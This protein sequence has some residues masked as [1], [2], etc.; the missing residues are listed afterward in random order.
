MTGI[1][2]NT[3]LRQTAKLSPAQIQVIRMLEIPAVELRQRVEEEIQ[4]NPLLEEVPEYERKDQET[5][6][7]RD[8]YEDDYLYED[9]LSDSP[10]KGDELDDYDSF[11]DPDE[12]YTAANDSVDINDAYAA[13][14]FDDEY[15]IPNYRTE[16]NNYSADD[17]PR[18]EEIPFSIGNTFHEYLLE[19]IGERSLSDKERSIAEYV[20]GSID[21][22]GWLTRTAEQ[23][24]DDL[25]FHAGVDVS[26]AEMEKVVAMVRELD[27]PG[28]GAYNL[29]DCLLIQLNRRPETEEN[30][31]AK[32]VIERYFTDF[33][34]RHF[35][36]IRQ[37]MDLTEE[38]MKDVLTEISHLN[39]KPGNSFGG[40]VYESNGNQITPD[41]YVTT[42]DGQLVVALNTGDIPDLR[43]NQEYVTMLDSLNQEGA[44][45]KEQR[46][47]NKDGIRF[48]KQHIDSAKWFI[49]AI[50][51]RNE[52]LMRTMEAIVR[53]QHDYFVEGDETYLKPMI[54]QD[55]ADATGYDV[56]TISRVSNSK[57]VQTDFG[58]FPLKHF[59][60]EGLATE[61]GD[62]VST[63]EIKKV[64]KEVIGKED[65]RHPLNDDQL[66]RLLKEENYIVARRTVAKYREQ[67]GI[68]VARLRKQ[69]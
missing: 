27:P 6:D 4:Q 3:D 22:N 55:I 37:R 30:L 43:I 11:G 63:R 64:L 54:L 24:V 19:Q 8:E 20:V 35:E 31:L 9:T 38:Q 39:P 2:L 16:T 1:S 13:G 49:D 69:V 60:S 65:K 66:V 48:I 46:A 52:T 45:N 61:L 14:D 12:N 18:G 42:E 47:R 21:D 28:V 32:R 53:C 17:D 33:H 50:R 68:P 59:F 15:D 44:K 25:A 36:R 58:T 23:M 29:Q 5:R 34:K 67:L 10:S 56:S 40:T 62:E 41:F 57:Y 7:E 26:D 51:Q